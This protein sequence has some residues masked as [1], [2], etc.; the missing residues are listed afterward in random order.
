MPNRPTFGQLYPSP[1]LFVTSMEFLSACIKHFTSSADFSL[2]GRTERAGSL[3]ECLFNVHYIML[4]CE[5]DLSSVTT[6]V[7][8]V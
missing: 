6:L 7:D 4:F 8:A 1:Y 5:E 3:I 2:H